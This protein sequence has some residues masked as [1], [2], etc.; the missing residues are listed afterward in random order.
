MTDATGGG[1]TADA[2]NMEEGGSK[3]GSIRRLSQMIND[4]GGQPPE[5]KDS[6]SIGPSDPV[7]LAWADVTLSIPP[8]KPNI[9]QRI[10]NP[11][12]YKA[13]KADHA[14][15]T[16]LRGCL[17][18]VRPGELIGIMGE[19]GAG[20][21]KLLEAISGK[22]KEG[23]SPKGTVIVNGGRR[24][25][26]GWARLVSYVEVEDRHDPNLTLQERVQLACRLKM[27][28]AEY[29]AGQMD[30]IAGKIIKALGLEHL[31][32]TRC[33]H[34]STG[35]LRRLSI[36]VELAAQRHLICI[37][38][39]THGLDSASALKLTEMLRDLAMEYS[40]SIICVIHAPTASVLELFDR[41]LLLSRGMPVYYGNLEETLRHLQAV[42]E[43]EIP[44]R[45][46]P[47]DYIIDM[48]STDRLS[49]GTRRMSEHRYTAFKREWELIEERVLER[50]PP[51]RMA[52]VQSRSSSRSSVN[53][54]RR[55]VRSDG[56]EN[57]GPE[58]PN[59]QWYEFRHLF[60]RYWRAEFRDHR[61]WISFIIFFTILALFHGFLYFQL[62]LA[63]FGGFQSRLGL[64][65][66]IP[67]VLITIMTGQ[68]AGQFMGA[69]QMIT[70]ERA[71]HSYRLLPA[72]GAKFLA[73]V[74]LRLFTF[75]LFGTIV[76]YLAGLRTDSFVYFLIFMGFFWLTLL[77]F[78]ALGVILATLNIPLLG[79]YLGVGFFAL[80]GLPIRIP[81]MTPILAWLRYLSPAYYSLLG[82][83]QNEASGLMF[84][85][86][87]SGDEYIAQFGMDETSVMWCAGAL[88]ITF[89]GYMVI[90]YFGLNHKTR[91]RFIII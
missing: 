64:L 7:K 77:V 37:D 4:F 65:V 85:D 51:S 84:G 69:M 89:A 54:F 38:E 20:K 9:L 10:V 90:G 56:D 21:T 8:P 87:V 32:G 45:E 18:E 5:G 25:P 63:D 2:G 76:Y 1:A 83:I 30:R 34:L 26:Q 80:C 11:S 6:Q 17:G 55:S 3:H 66:N 13:W 82:L 31:K 14:G 35:E 71:S 16:I 12:R 53:L 72:Y 61:N 49:S 86:G 74:P 60:L 41:I 39:P 73:L 75:T 36:A 27:S 44:K 62:T 81:D 58:W 43:K 50:R 28:S 24:V 88:M 19:S 15:K 47:A 48:V 91:P 70:K 68:L 33:K 42:T 79:V 29:D 23:S 52:S 57:K 67:S 40:L 78:M 22:L 46:N 59:S